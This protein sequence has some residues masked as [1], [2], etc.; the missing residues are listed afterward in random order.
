MCTAL[1]CPAHAMVGA[2]DCTKESGQMTRAAE[3]GNAETQ[4]FLGVM[5]D[6]GEG[7]SENNAEAVRWYREAD[8]Q[9]HSRAQAIL[10]LKYAKGEGVPEDYVRAYAWLSIAVARGDEQAKKIKKAL[11]ATMTPD[12]IAEAQRLSREYWE[13]SGRGNRLE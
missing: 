8:E 7:V 9:G 3:Q 10:G 12:A 1:A 6:F 5:Y 11:V 4:F 13:S 2:F